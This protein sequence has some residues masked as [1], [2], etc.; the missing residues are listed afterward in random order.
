MTAPTMK[1]KVSFRTCRRGEVLA[2]LPKAVGQTSVARVRSEPFDG[3][4]D[5]EAV[6]P[7]VTVEVTEEV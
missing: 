4:T 7:P 5:W 1:V 3:L 2:P 6:V